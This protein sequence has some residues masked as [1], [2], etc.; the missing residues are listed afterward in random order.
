MIYSFIVQFIN[1][2]YKLKDAPA[3]IILELDPKSATKTIYLFI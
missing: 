1:S 3:E 2:A